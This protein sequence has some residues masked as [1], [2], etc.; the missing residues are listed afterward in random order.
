MWSPRTLKEV[1]RIRGRTECLEISIINRVLISCDLNVLCIFQD[2]L[3][4]ANVHRV[5]KFILHTNYPGHYD[6]NT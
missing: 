5:K 3:F 2:I 4:D 1:A 6:F